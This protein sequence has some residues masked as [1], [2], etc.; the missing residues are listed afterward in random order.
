MSTSAG[1]KS[2]CLF[3]DIQF[4]CTFR[5]LNNFFLQF[6]FRHN[7]G[8][9]LPTIFFTSFRSLLSA[10]NFLFNRG[11]YRVIFMRSQWGEF[12]ELLISRNL[13]EIELNGVHFWR[14]CFLELFEAKIQ[15]FDQKMF[16]IFLHH[17]GVFLPTIFLLHFANYYGA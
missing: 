7:S 5:S 17:S 3:Q 10:L 11:Y 8:V 15:N 9:F 12:K 6:F 13:L 4:F 2:V 16:Y 14:L 1:D